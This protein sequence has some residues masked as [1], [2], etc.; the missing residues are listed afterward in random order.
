MEAQ[1]SDPGARRTVRTRQPGLACA[2]GVVFING[3]AFTLF[4]A[5]RRSFQIAATPAGTIRVWNRN[6]PH[7]PTAQTRRSTGTG[8]VEIRTNAAQYPPRKRPGRI[9]YAARNGLG[10]APTDR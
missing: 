4:V 1:S 3:D 6:T 8:V 7:R 10:Q 2:K 9:D 5:G